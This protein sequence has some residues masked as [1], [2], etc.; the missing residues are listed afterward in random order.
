MAIVGE[1]VAAAFKVTARRLQER[2]WLSDPLLLASIHHGHDR[3]GEAC[4]AGG[5]GGEVSGCQVLEETPKV[6]VCGHGGSRDQVNVS[7]AQDYD[8]R[9]LGCDRCP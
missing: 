8:H 5:G 3:V 1:V 9:D 2:S 7:C 6:S 4:G